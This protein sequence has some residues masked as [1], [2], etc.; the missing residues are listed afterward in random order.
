MTSDD[1]DLLV[2]GAGR[3]GL[4]AALTALRARPTLRLA[5][6]DALPQPGGTMRTQR[7]NG[8]LCEL[9]PF[10]FAR[11]EVTPLL[12]L[13]P[14]PPRLIEC[15]ESGRRGLLITP[16]G[17]QPIAV[18]PLPV[19]FAAGNEELPQACRRALG[20]AL[21]LGRE[22]V[23]IT[24]A[25]DR[26]LVELGG[27]VRHALTTS[28]LLL[29]V[30]PPAAGRHLGN[31]DPALAEVAQRCES[32]QVAYAWFGGDRGQ[33]PT[34]VGY[35]AVP[36]EDLPSPLAEAICC[37]QVFPGRALPGRFLVRCELTTPPA[38]DDEA[39][40]TAATELRRWTGTTAAFG[41]QKLHRFAVPVLDGAWVECRMRLQHLPR[42]VPGLRLA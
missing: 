25:G 34:L 37:D 19:S 6:V 17:A 7:S 42:R 12:D 38:S 2:V 41:F 5:V 3:T 30:P 18:E 4:T 40:N 27:E 22:V 8:F 39:L 36:R 13:L 23:A 16:G 1:L 31:F 9:G 14:A 20:P 28:E 26:F 21:R 32:R 35:G 15:L 33:A 24:P 11:E 29:A 10:A